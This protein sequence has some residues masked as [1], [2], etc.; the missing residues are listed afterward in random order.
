MDVV[1]RR[2]M[3]KRMRDRDDDCDCCMVNVCCV[4]WKVL[5]IRS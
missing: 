5:V 4:V 1:E 3:V 2:E